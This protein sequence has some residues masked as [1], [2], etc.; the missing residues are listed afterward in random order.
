MQL[1]IIYS[2][3]TLLSHSTPILYPFEANVL[4]FLVS[5]TANIYL[6]KRTNIYLFK[7]HRSGVFIVN[8]ENISHLFLAFLLLTLNK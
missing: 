1:R 5:I 4:P 8:F 6:F 7:R 3:F 2:L